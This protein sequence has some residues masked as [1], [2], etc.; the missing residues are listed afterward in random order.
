MSL[1]QLRAVR[2]AGKR[3]DSVVVLIGRPFTVDDDAGVVVLTDSPE[4]TDLRP[5]L[6]MPVHV[7]DLQD[8]DTRTLAVLKALQ[9]LKVKPLGVCG[10]AGTCGLSKEHEYAMERYRESLCRT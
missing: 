4:A 10:R 5:L 1:E 2:K 9:A 7:I 8:D 3:P 6:G